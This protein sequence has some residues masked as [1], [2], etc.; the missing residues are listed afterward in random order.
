MLLRTLTRLMPELTQFDIAKSMMRYM[1]PKYSAAFALLSV[2][3][4]SRLPRPPAR[5]TATALLGH[6]NDRCSNMVTLSRKVLLRLIV[7]TVNTARHHDGGTL[8]ALIWLLAVRRLYGA[9]ALSSRFILK[10]QLAESKRTRIEA[11]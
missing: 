3:S 11:G 10:P 8:S 7:P 4:Y 5:I 1:P 2:S 9:A 6:R